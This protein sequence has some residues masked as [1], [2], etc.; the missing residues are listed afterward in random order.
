MAEGTD[1]DSQ[2]PLHAFVVISNSTH[3]GMLIFLVWPAVGE[4]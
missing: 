2:K 1:H 3:P 4:K